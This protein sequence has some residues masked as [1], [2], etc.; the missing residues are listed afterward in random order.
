[1]TDDED[2][3]GRAGGALAAGDRDR[4]ALRRTA[5]LVRSSMTAAGARSVSSGKW[6]AETMLD[7]AP[8]VPARDLPT[9]R[10][11]HGQSGPELAHVLIRNAART[12][13]AMGAVAGGVAGVSE[14]APPTWLALP[15][16][17]V[18]ET[19]AVVAVEMKLVAELHA[20]YER[21][22]TGTP[23]ERGA[24][25]ARA[26]AERRGV[27]ARDLVRAGGLSKALG[28][29]TRRELTRVLQRRLAGRALRNLP[30]LAPFLAGAVAGAEINR[31]ATRSLGEAVARDLVAVRRPGG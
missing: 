23:T 27:T 7:A 12:T 6:L 8:H 5:G 30:T 9:L 15:A 31:R 2:D 26:W 17:L 22:V 11:H 10:A 18:V 24:A 20:V 28:Q 16:E 1:M 21:P 14:M 13:A 19:L 25:V 29:S 3:L 4:H